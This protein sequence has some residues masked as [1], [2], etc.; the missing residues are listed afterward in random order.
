[1]ASAAARTCLSVPCVV[2]TIHGR[3]SSMSNLADNAAILAFP[4]RGEVAERL[5]AAVC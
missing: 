5:K 3:Q 2:H 1:M 4:A